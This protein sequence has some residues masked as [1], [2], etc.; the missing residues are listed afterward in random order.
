MNSIKEQIST[1]AHDL[2]NLEVNTI[3]KAD[4]TGR[5]MPN[6]RHALIDIAQKYA[7]KLAA[8]GFALNRDVIK[9]GSFSSFH[10]IRETARGAIKS[11]EAKAETKGLSKAEEADFVMLQRIKSMSDQI[12]GIFNA[13]EKRTGKECKNDF[14]REDI[15]KGLAPLRLNGDEL[16]SIRKIWEVGVQE[17]AI[18]TV[19]QMDGDV[20]T[21]VQP[22]YACVKNDELH[23]LHNQAVNTSIHFWKEL[24]G[25]VNDCLKSLLKLVFQ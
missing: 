23:S 14:S 24:I 3:V 21:R 5:K 16:V 22:Q 18:Q 20:I 13:L 11:L 2:M 10:K 9:L 8:L 19:I 1:I 17:I 25:I 6:P 12:K 4:I 7:M 15:E